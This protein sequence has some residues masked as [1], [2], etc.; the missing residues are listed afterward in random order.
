MPRRP[1]TLAAT[2]RS[3]ESIMLPTDPHRIIAAW[4]ESDRREA[5]KARKEKRQ[6][7]IKDE[8]TVAGRR[9]LC[10]CD[11]LF[12]G[13]DARGYSWTYQCYFLATVWFEI[14]GRSI[15]WSLR[16]ETCPRRVSLS[17]AELKDPE[18]I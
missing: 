1:A 5:E 12:K 18:K 3:A 13:A 2:L 10:I 9:K 7:R 14:D 8:D 6:P 11:A 16:E 15:R 17:K 4:M